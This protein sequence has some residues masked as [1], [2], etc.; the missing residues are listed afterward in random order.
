MKALFA[1]ELGADEAGRQVQRWRM[2]F[3]ACAEL[4]GF[5]G[6]REWLVTHAL[7]APQAGGGAR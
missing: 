7:L 3:L 2:F 4:F 6:G 5:E 1:S